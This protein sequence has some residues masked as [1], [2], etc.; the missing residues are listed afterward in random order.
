MSELGYKAVLEM[1]GHKQLFACM[2]PAQNCAD[3]AEEGHRTR[4]PNC[5]HASMCELSAMTLYA[6]NSLPKPSKRFAIFSPCL[7]KI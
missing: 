4:Q 5:W 6:A 2:D 7:C 3:P 1:L